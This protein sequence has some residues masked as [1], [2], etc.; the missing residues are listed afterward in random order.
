MHQGL[1]SEPKIYRY[2]K[3]LFPEKLARCGNISAKEKRG[4]DPQL[5][6]DVINLLKSLNKWKNQSCF[7]IPFRSLHTSI[8]IYEHLKSMKP[9]D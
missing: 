2:S 1:H 8:Y 6:A 9:I 4:R 7:M 3:W 5:T